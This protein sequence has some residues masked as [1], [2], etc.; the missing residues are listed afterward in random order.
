MAHEPTGRFVTPVTQT[1]PLPDAG[2]GRR[3]AASYA[4]PDEAMAASL[5][6]AADRG[7]AAEARI[8]QAATALIDGIRRKAGGLGG[9]EGFL[10]AYSLSTKEGLALMVLAEALLRVPDAATADRLIEDKLA[11]GDWSK[12]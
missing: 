5:L 12:T 3:F 11:T 7:V 4:P 9:I 2:A 8:D 10:H 6:A 1:T